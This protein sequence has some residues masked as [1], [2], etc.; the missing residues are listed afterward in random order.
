MADKGVRSKKGVHIARPGAGESVRHITQ[1]DEDRRRFSEEFRK[2]KEYKQ[3]IKEER[4]ASI[5]ERRKKR[6]P[7]G[8]SGGGIN[9][10]V[11]SD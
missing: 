10:E 4:F 2:D 11:T 1:T 5:K 3:R 8:S 6:A 7:S 9:I